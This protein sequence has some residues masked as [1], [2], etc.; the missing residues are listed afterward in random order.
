MFCGVQF[1][2]VAANNHASPIGVLP[3][4]NPATSSPPASF[5][6]PIPSNKI[7]K[8]VTS[9]T[10]VVDTVSG[11]R[12]DAYTS[13]IDHRIR[14]AW[15]FT[16]YLDERNS[17]VVAKQLYIYSASSNPLVQ[18]ILYR[19]LKQAAR[20]ELLKTASH[21]REDELYLEA[22]MAFLALSTLL[23]ED[24]HFFG[25]DKPTLFDASV[26]AYNHLLLDES[27]GWQ[28]TRLADSL[29]NMDNLVQH[30]Q[31]LLTSYFHG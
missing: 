15:L 1:K 6:Q 3:Y 9:E 8:W 26:F 20:D 2:T 29:R 5:S 14:S 27:L 31:R 24:G 7:L 28:N 17:E 25:K 10:E 22:E 18:M 16:L 21:I 30:R 23:G 11:M 19:Q 12:Y 13:L 4:L